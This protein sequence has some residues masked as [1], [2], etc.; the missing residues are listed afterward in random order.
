[1]IVKNSDLKIYSR[2]EIDAL[3]KAKLS[4]NFATIQKSME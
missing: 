3:E 4:D 1:M 2:N